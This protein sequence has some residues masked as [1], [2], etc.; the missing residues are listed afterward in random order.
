[1]MLNVGFQRQ[2]TRDC[3]LHGGARIG[4]LR[5]SFPSTSLR[6]QKNQLVLKIAFVG[7]YSFSPEQV[8]AIEEDTFIPFCAWGIR[9]RHNITTYPKYIAFKYLG[10]PQCLIRSIREAG[11]EPKATPDSIP[12]D[13]GVPVRWG[14][15]IGLVIFW[16][17]LSYLDHRLFCESIRGILGL[18]GVFLL[19]IGS[20]AVRWSPFLQRIILKPGRSCDEIKAW[21]SLFALCSGIL[22]VLMVYLAV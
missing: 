8:V 11:F 7:T 14:T 16:N 5:F 12:A 3:V 13:R 18:V 22:F 20:F 15:L 10:G 9:I 4:W 6:V 2:V 17:A 21:L 1:M 19:F